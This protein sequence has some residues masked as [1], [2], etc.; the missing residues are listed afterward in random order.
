MPC[1][2]TLAFHSCT[3]GAVTRFNS[4]SCSSLKVSLVKR[5]SFCSLFLVMASCASR[6]RALAK[7]SSAP[8]FSMIFF[9][10]SGS[11]YQRARFITTIS[12]GAARCA[13]IAT[14]SWS[15]RSFPPAPLVVVVESQP[16]AMA[17]T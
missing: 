2:A 13:S 8:R 15:D 7:A 12:A 17:S 6:M 10:S 9:R 1:F 14:L 16:K 3:A 11:A 5:G 4:A